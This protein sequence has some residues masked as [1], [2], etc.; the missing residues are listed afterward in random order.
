MLLLFLTTV[1][2]FPTH[3]YQ[4][5][6]VC[7]SG[8]LK[9]EI[10]RGNS[11]TESKMI[12]FGLIVPWNF[13][14]FWKGSA[15]FDSELMY[16]QCKWDHFTKSSQEALVERLKKVNVDLK[17]ENGCVEINNL[18]HCTR[19]QSEHNYF[20]HLILYVGI[21]IV[22]MLLTSQKIHQLRKMWF[23]NQFG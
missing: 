5:F 6:D 10:N 20:I 17:L 8:R 12:F 14:G 13:V 21:L 1:K 23:G 15:T 18:R 9:L 2:A 3:F 4:M 7:P 11:G 19:K 22:N 16:F